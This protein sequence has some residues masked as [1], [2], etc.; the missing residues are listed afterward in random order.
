MPPPFRQRG[1]TVVLSQFSLTPSECQ[2]MG[3]DYGLTPHTHGNQL[4]NSS[5][6]LLETLEQDDKFEAK[7]D[8]IAVIVHRFV[9]RAT[10]VFDL[11][12]AVNGW[13]AAVSKQMNVS[14]SDFKVNKIEVSGLDARRVE[15]VGST[16][17][18]VRCAYVAVQH[19]RRFWTVEAFTRSEAGAL[20]GDRIIRSIEIRY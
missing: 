16:T 12:G 2:Q 10:V 9:H 18:P 14:T 19:E 5:P 11:D 7:T 3:R 8:V 13:I 4:S 6:R 17:H 20:A 15:F 1:Q